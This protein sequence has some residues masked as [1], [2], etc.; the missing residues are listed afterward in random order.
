V[1]NLRNSLYK[2]PQI[3]LPDKSPE[4]P[5]EHTTSTV[6]F[7][8]YPQ[9][10]LLDRQKEADDKNLIQKICS[11][12][13]PTNN[14]TVLVSVPS[15]ESGDVVRNDTATVI[16]PGL[17]P[18]LITQ[19]SVDEKIKIPDDLLLPTKSDIINEPIRI[20]QT[21]LEEDDDY[22]AEAEEKPIDK[23]PG[24]VFVGKIFIVLF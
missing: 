15:T 2:L 23:S 12:V 17:K 24:S 10:I 20:K 1:F 7:S 14:T 18:P 22:D 4:K 6:T 5:N 19:Q 21:S 9:E 13:D 11:S 8:L 16:S 3:P